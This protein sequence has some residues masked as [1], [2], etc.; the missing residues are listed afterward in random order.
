MSGS[1][2]ST[3][4]EATRPGPSTVTVPGYPEVRQRTRAK[5]RVL[6]DALP[7]MREHAGA[8][9]VVKVGGAAIEDGALGATFA[10]DVSLLR[11]VGVRPVIV[12]GGG[13][14]ITATAR[15]LGIEP[16]FVAG[17]RVTDPETL[18]VARMVL[19]GLIN[20][21]LVALL[22][23]HGTPAVGLSGLDG[24][25]LRVRPRAP[26]LGLV[27]EVEEVNVD[28]LHH[29]MGQY[30][31]VIASVGA[32]G[33]GQA[34]NVNADLVAGAVASWLR[35]QKL[36]YL[37]DVPGLFGPDGQFISELGAS[38]CERLLKQG[39]VEGGMVPKLRSA[40]DALARG[41][42]RAHL[43]DGRVEHALILE[44]FT[45][46][47]LGTMVTPDPSD[48]PTGGPAEG[49]SSEAGP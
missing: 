14:Q 2:A 18:T 36:V 3:P 48:G 11:L 17:H 37:T 22:V 27:G 43:I 28:L 33:Q 34:Y 49:S 20:Q 30:V 41:V 19:V 6:L 35:A 24:G 45:P 9:V 5:A 32:D 47:G 13:P 7:F 29:L 21:D 42:R 39:A 15:R 16:T 25:L 26:E 10:E 23:R 12:H 1:T 40:L 8:V 4:P 46:E 38:D 31:P 44:L